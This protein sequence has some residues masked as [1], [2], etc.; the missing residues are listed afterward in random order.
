MFQSNHQA[1]YAPK[2]NIT[3][4]H[5]LFYL[6]QLSVLLLKLMFGGEVGCL[7]TRL[8]EQNE[9]HCNVF[10]ELRKRELDSLRKG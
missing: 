5:E 7:P 2:T 9:N 10:E 3:L 4:K 8:T 1:D 6:A